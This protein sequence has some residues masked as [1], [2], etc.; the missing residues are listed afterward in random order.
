M[1]SYSYKRIPAPLKSS[2]LLTPSSLSPQAV[3]RYLI[4]RGASL[5]AFVFDFSEREA[6]SWSSSAAAGRRWFFDC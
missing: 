4:V 2:Y 5:A 6:R 3:A 1:A